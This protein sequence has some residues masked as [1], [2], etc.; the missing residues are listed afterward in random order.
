MPIS[1]GWGQC[2]A[3]CQQVRGRLK[4]LQSDL[5]SEV[6]AESLSLADSKDV[7]Q[8]KPVEVPACREHDIGKHSHHGTCLR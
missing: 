1:S 3:V 5:R 8:G 7:N 2:R 6:V 4:H